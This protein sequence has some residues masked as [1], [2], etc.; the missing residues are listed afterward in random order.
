MNLKSKLARACTS[1]YFFEISHLFKKAKAASI[2]GAVALVLVSPLPGEPSVHEIDLSNLSLLPAAP[3]CGL[4]L[5]L[6]NHDVATFVVGSDAA[7]AFLQ[8][9]NF[10]SDGT[11][12]VN[13]EI[14]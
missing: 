8:V 9:I 2:A 13:L 3:H 12:S 7:T 11:K 6:G 4:T 14:R 10:R 5:T 1:T